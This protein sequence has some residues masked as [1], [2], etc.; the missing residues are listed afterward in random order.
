M[1]NNKIITGALLLFMLL[2]SFVS[3]GESTDFITSYQWDTQYFQDNLGYQDYKYGIPCTMEF[4]ISLTYAGDNCED[5][6]PYSVDDYPRYILNNVYITSTCN[7]TNVLSSMNNTS[8]AIIWY[9]G[10]EIRTQLNESTGSIGTQRTPPSYFMNVSCGVSGKICVLEQSVEEQYICLHPDYDDMTEEEQKLLISIPGWDG[11]ADMNTYKFNRSIAITNNVSVKTLLSV[12][13]WTPSGFPYTTWGTVLTHNKYFEAG[14]ELT[15]LFDT[16]QQEEAED[17]YDND[18]DVIINITL[19]PDSVT[20]ENGDLYLFECDHA[21][22]YVSEGDGDDFNLLRE[23]CVN[24]F[25]SGASPDEYGDYSQDNIESEKFS[26]LLVYRYPSTPETFI[27]SDIA[28]GIETDPL[29]HLMIYGGDQDVYK[30]CFKVQDGLMGT[31]ITN[32]DLYDAIGSIAWGSIGVE[33]DSWCVNWDALDEYHVRIDKDGYTQTGT[34]TFFFKSTLETYTLLMTQDTTNPDN[35][36]NLSFQVNDSDG[37]PL[38]NIDVLIQCEGNGE[39]YYNQH[40]TTNSDGNIFIENL[41][42][43]WVCK[44]YFDDITDEYENREIVVII[45]DSGEIEIELPDNDDYEN[46]RS[47]TVLVFIKDQDDPI[48]TARV[49]VKGCGEPEKIQYTGRDGKALFNGLDKQCPYLFDVTHNDYFSDL[50]HALSGSAQ[51]VSYLVSTVTSSQSKLNLVLKFNGTL[52][53]VKVNIMDGESIIASEDTNYNGYCDFF[54]YANKE[55]T[56]Q[57]EFRGYEIKQGFTTTRGGDH[58]DL[59]LDFLAEDDEEKQNTLAFENLVYNVL[60]PVLELILIVFAF[61]LLINV[62][63]KKW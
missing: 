22:Y 62:L 44:V 17:I 52:V 10:N 32:F 59:I 49:V 63:T 4:D 42:Q 23:N 57:S 60:Y 56:I 37:N 31:P 54:L 11:I 3:A 28:F 18:K 7:E 2:I 30:M 14:T 16:G 51:T 13:P 19:I 27:F 9:W 39:I 58:L 24:L 48:N 53:S 34:D 55:Y 6:V 21:D 35:Y 33:S 38:D 41:T 8:E 45:G 40:H 29:I 47:A 36:R 12:M 46:L 50:N 26:L 61:K 15:G 5:N 25:T 1:K 43:E 20:I